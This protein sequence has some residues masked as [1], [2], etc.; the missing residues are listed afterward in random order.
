MSHPIRARFKFLKY[1]KH[2]PG[3]DFCYALIYFFPVVGNLHVEISNYFG[4]NTLNITLD[5]N[6]FL[7]N[8][9]LQKMEIVSDENGG[10]WKLELG[11]I[12]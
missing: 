2:S 10:I 7:R 11:V 5:G 4:L 12:T 9:T 8:S 3:E 1:R 6:C